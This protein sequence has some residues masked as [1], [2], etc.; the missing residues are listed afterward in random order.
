MFR[1]GPTN[2]TLSQHK[3][4]CLQSKVSQ[5]KHQRQSRQP[6]A[7]RLR[8]Q[9]VWFCEC[10]VCFCSF[11]C[12]FAHFWML[13]SVFGV[14]RIFCVFLCTRGALGLLYAALGALVS[15][16]WH[17]WSCLGTVLDALE[18]VLGHLWEAL[19]AILGLSCKKTRKN[20]KNSQI[21]IQLGRQNGGQ[22]H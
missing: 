16:S 22:N 8:A 6:N 12:G 7:D 5:R 19:V 17:P 4:G 1:I 20:K 13:L 9:G 14:L 11:L 15:R 18:A 21:L 2:K 10:F 3:G